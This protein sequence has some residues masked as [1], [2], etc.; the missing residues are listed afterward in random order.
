M[1]I[2]ALPTLSA[3]QKSVPFTGLAQPAVLRGEQ[4][5]PETGERRDRKDSFGPLAGDGLRQAVP[6]A[7]QPTDGLA[8]P[9]GVPV[10]E[11]GRVGGKATAADQRTADL[12]RGLS[13]SVG[14]NGGLT[15]GTT[16]IPFA[17]DSRRR[18]EPL[19]LRAS[20]DSTTL[21][22]EARDRRGNRFDASVDLST[23]RVNVRRNGQGAGSTVASVNPVHHW[24]Q[25]QAGKGP[26]TRGVDLPNYV[27]G[28][29]PEVA[30]IFGGIANPHDLAKPSRFAETP[31]RLDGMPALTGPANGGDSQVLMNP[32]QVREAAS[33]LGGGANLDR[34]VDGARNNEL[35]HVMWGRMFDRA[36]SASGRP[37][38]GPEYERARGDAWMGGQYFDRFPLNLSGTQPRGVRNVHVNELVSD[39]TSMATDPRREVNRILFN[40]YR[41]PLNGQ[42]D[43]SH[44]VMHDAY[45]RAIQA[46]DPTARVADITSRL[47]REKARPEDGSA[48]LGDRLGL[49]PAD[50]TFIQQYFEAYAR[51]AVQH[52]SDELGRRYR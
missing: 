36:W 51:R 24:E 11:L 43:L 23:M 38:S 50:Y 49:Q 5:E 20:S 7:H 15:V 3:P 48:P 25:L 2:P 37:T 12:V 33:T 21:N 40:A 27:P 47:A 8:T 31:F 17:N 35:S 32:S 28:D 30:R 46:R 4:R 6:V 42:Y 9:G 10:P 18:G 1:S 13:V 14:R 52:Y 34:F 41:G 22:I 29:R 19:E 39:A 44:N 16:T 45:V 26:L